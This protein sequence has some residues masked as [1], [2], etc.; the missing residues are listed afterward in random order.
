MNPTHDVSLFI[1]GMLAAGYAV[2]ALYFL[3]FRRHTHDR[4]FGF[5]AAAFGLLFVQRCALTLASGLIA[6]TA[7]YYVVRLLAFALIIVAI[8]DKNR[9][10]RD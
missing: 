5:F 8:V 6:D 7:W 2:A 1:S 10:A 9:A 4:L 3:K